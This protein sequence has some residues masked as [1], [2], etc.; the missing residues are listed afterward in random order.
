VAAMSKEAAYKSVLS[1]INK[2]NDPNNGATTQELEQLDRALE[3]VIDDVKEHIKLRRQDEG[4]S[5]E[6]RIIEKIEKWQ[7]LDAMKEEA[8]DHTRCPEC[9]DQLYFCDCTG[10]I[11][12]E[13]L[14]NHAEW[15]LKKA[16]EG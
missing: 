6:S 3:L 14:L 10:R 12:D 9:R 15:I 2:W 11:A 7:K 5:Q 1:L 13:L 16:K 8:D 4:P